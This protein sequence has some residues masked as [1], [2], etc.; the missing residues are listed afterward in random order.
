[1]MGLQRLASRAA[2]N[3]L[4]R[5]VL[6]NSGY[7]LSANG[8]ATAGSMLQG[9][10][11]ARLIG[12]EGLGI[13]GLVTDFAT[14]LN[15]LTSFRMGQLVVRYVG[16]FSAA[17]DE[18]K[19][20]AAFKAAGLIEIASSLLAVI[21]IL[22]LAPLAAEYLAHAPETAPLFMLYGLA[23]LANLM[24]ESAIGLLQLSDRFGLLA[25]ITVGQSL[26]T[27][28][29]MTLV[30]ASGGGL[31]QV[32]LVYTLGKAS[33]A[34]ATT[35]LA[36][37]E[38]RRR[39]GRGWWRA[40]LP[41]LSSR[42]REMA[43]FATSTNL[44]STITLIT[45]DSELLWLGLLSDPVQ[46]GYYKI[47]RALAGVVYLPVEP[48]I[49]TTYRE[50]SV[51][52]NHRRW[53][54][55]RYLLRSGSLLAGAWTL[56]A[57]FGLAVFG[58]WIIRIVYTAEFLPSYPVLVVLLVGAAAVNIFYWNRSLLLLL[59][60]P[61]YPNWV[62]GITGTFKILGSILWVPVGGAMAMAA[63]LSGYFAVTTGVLVRKS[64]QV[65]RRVQAAPSGE[66]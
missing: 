15:R 48:M 2:A 25:R 29:L 62:H 65:L 45:R 7:L 64:I 50:T 33:G 53:P 30:F 21:L 19:A 14:N 51:E 20:A 41:S 66:G 32:V 23:I 40:R 49:S 63:M 46:V 60:M 11:A 26:L 5:R 27:L 34:V 54:N 6:R 1:M 55:V 22:V 3:P 10:L 61:D 44:G 57:V 58:P 31:T 47:A 4:L 12:V 8:L 17:D 38:A 24:N 42:W 37:V 28:V 35:A 56:V 36:V 52:V 13:V 43:R 59:G 18:E 39:W 16:E 9:A